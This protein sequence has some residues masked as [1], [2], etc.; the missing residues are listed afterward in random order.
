[1]LLVFLR[2]VAQS[3]PAARVAV[4]WQ[5]IPARLMDGIRAVSPHADFIETTFDF[6]R[7]PLTRIS[8]KVLCWARGAGEFEGEKQ[9]VFCDSDTLVRRDLAWAF[10]GREDVVFTAKPENVPLNTGVMLARGGAA[11][12]AF[13]RAWCAATV[14]ILETPEL[15]AQ[16]NDQSLPY[17]GTDQ[18]SLY[19]MLDYSRDRAVYEV[20]GATLRAEPCARLNE[21]NSRHL[22]DEICV[23]HYKAGW[24]AILLRGRPFSRFRPRAESW[25]MLTLFLE[26]FLAALRD[27]NRETDSGLTAHDYGIAWPWYWRD[28]RFS[29]PLYAVWRVK[30]ALERGWLMLRG[31]LKPGM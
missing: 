2:S 7:D 1:M 12:T 14:R 3:H 5:D 19:Q 30:A 23:V 4:Y 9:L 21:T 18:M 28:G 13:F 25:E 29:A 16:A 8:S 22:S 24:Q 26:T 11:T 15:F 10:A 6:A 20:S 17:G 31:E 27:V